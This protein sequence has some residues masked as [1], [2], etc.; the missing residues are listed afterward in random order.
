MTFKQ[1]KLHEVQGGPLGV[2]MWLAE[3]YSDDPWDV[4]ASEVTV[5]HFIE[6]DQT[7]LVRHRDDHLELVP[8]QLL[9]DRRRDA[10]RAA[11]QKLM[12]DREQATRGIESIGEQMTEEDPHGET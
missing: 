9:G 2:S 3:W 12:R 4:S 7:A 6:E 10:F 8:A 1:E 5:L 11:I